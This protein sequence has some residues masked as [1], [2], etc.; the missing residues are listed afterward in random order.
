MKV[1]VDL[2][3]AVWKLTALDER[4]VLEAIDGLHTIEQVEALRNVERR[5][6]GRIVVDRHCLRRIRE[7]GEPS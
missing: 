3:G 4:A 6:H 1:D 2:F 5:T 7:L